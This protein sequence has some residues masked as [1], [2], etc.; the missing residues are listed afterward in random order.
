MLTIIIRKTDME[1]NFITNLLLCR[2]YGI[3]FLQIVPLVSVYLRSR[4][5]HSLSVFLVLMWQA[6]RSNY[7][8]VLH[9]L[10]SFL[11]ESKRAL[12]TDP[13][14]RSNQA[15]PSPQH[16]RSPLS[17]PILP[18]LERASVEAQLYHRVPQSEGNHR[19]SLGCWELP[20]HRSDPALLERRSQHLRCSRC[21]QS[22]WLSPTDE[23]N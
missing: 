2:L 22:S 10:G 16:Q 14:L 8:F 21:S 6:C 12:P 1:W 23:L 13:A 17:G 5:V 19:H 3:H 4:L 15:R 20:R 11:Y 18:H 7:L 9:T